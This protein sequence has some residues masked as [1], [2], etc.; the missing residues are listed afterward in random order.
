MSA[1]GLDGCGCGCGFGYGPSAAAAAG[2]SCYCY[3]VAACVCMLSMHCN[4]C[5][6][7]FGEYSTGLPLAF[8]HSCL[9]SVRL[10]CPWWLF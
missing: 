6:K 3:N 9:E 10:G 4:V 8:G 7:L 2:R 5:A 1:C